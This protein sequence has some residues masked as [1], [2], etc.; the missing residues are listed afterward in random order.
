MDDTQ[1]SHVPYEKKTRSQY[2]HIY[3]PPLTQQK[4]QCMTLSPKTVIVQK[5]ILLN[6]YTFSL[7]PS[8]HINLA[9]RSESTNLRALNFTILVEDSVGII[10]MH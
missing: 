8:G 4:Y 10:T 7:S 6:Q 3:T 5:K 1:Q 2:G 9:L